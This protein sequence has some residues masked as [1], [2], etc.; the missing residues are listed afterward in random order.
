MSFRNR[1]LKIARCACIPDNRQIAAELVTVA[2]KIVIDAPHWFL[3]VDD[4]DGVGWHDLRFRK[5]KRS[6]DAPVLTDFLY[7]AADQKLKAPRRGE[8]AERRERKSTRLNSSH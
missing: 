5:I 3:G 2:A 8:P 4:D 7:A 1:E 6:D